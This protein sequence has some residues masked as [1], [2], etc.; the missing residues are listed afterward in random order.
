MS[1]F[2]SLLQRQ[3]RHATDKDGRVDYDVL[4]SLVSQAYA[5]QDKARR[6]QDRATE[7]MSQELT[8]LNTAIRLERD[9]TVALSNKRFQLAVE[10]SN[11][12]IWDWDLSTGLV[13]FSHPFLKMLGRGEM[14][15]RQ[16]SF[17]A[18]YGFVSPED[19]AEA[20]KFI[21]S[22]LATTQTPPIMLRFSHTDGGFRYLLCRA[23]AIRDDGGRVVRMVGVH[24]DVTEMLQ[25]QNDLKEALARAETASQAKSDF[26]AN[27]SHEIRT[28]MNAI[29]GMTALLLET[30]LNSQQQMWA[31]IVRN[32][33]ESLLDII[34][35]ILDISKIEAGRLSLERAPFR[36]TDIIQHVTDTL[37]IK[38]REKNIELISAIRHEE[39]GL[40]IGDAV[41]VRQILLNLVSN[42]IKFTSIGHVL[43]QVTCGAV[44]L[45]SNVCPVRIEVIDTGIGIP[46]DKLDYIFEKFSQ[47]EES[48]TRRFGGTGLGL[49]ISKRLVDMMGG[50]IIVESIEGR[51]SSFCVE[52]GLPIDRASQQSE[53]D[54][55][56]SRLQIIEGLRVAIVEDHPLMRDILLYYFRFWHIP[57]VAFANS[58]E[59]IPALI[60]AE[61]ASEPYQLVLA[62]YHL[63]E[64]EGQ[65]FAKKIQ[66]AGVNRVI[67]TAL[68]HP[69]VIDQE[70][71]GLDGYSNSLIKPFMPLRLLDHLIKVWSGLKGNAAGGPV[72]VPVLETVKPAHDFSP[73]RILVVED[74]KANQ[75]YIQAVLKKFACTAEVAED[76]VIAV[77]KCSKNPYDVIFMDCHMPN[78]DGFEATA[79][80]R[81]MP[82]SQHAIIIALTADAMQ[83]DRERCLAAGM[84]DYLNKPVKPDHILAMLNRYGK[85]RGG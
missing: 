58:T 52:L 80:L 13:W 49:A 53:I 73:T 3:L 78:M 23:S 60:K 18:W 38:A 79:K 41:R 20:R 37:S 65:S 61:A 83:G 72:V 25:I 2:H 42:A 64:V 56:C 12:G 47:A 40:Y 9:E 11:D 30:K 48:T 28:P 10:T 46:K 55:L 36:L 82:I 27:M 66:Q 4:L 1:S 34:N 43:I 71:V 76:G 21:V 63:R 8:D 6:M 17:E 59:A 70:V 85:A 77:E 51:G 19:E 67:V 22:N 29:M 54:D 5:D 45:T 81:V 84:D 44:D 7:L 62:D 57:A 74:V 15:E 33:S 16:P 35:D 14:D 75:L 26:L 39:S 24:T 50:R 32:S 69:D 68:C 31:G